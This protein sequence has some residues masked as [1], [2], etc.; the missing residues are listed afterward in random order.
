MQ[1]I[2]AMDPDGDELVPSPSL[3]S[4]SDYGFD[5]ISHFSDAAVDVSEV[6]APVA[7]VAATG[8]PG[9]ALSSAS[10]GVVHRNE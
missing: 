3:P 10:A 9:N 4:C 2:G 1:L 8:L 7:P 5:V 6:V